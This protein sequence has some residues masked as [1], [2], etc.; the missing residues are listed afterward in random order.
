MAF[1]LLLGVAY[2]ETEPMS[3]VAGATGIAQ[4]P[5]GLELT[6]YGAG[7]IIGMMLWQIGSVPWRQL[8]RRFNRFLASKFEFYKFIIMATGCLVVLF[9]I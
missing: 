9:Y 1:G 7:M 4:I 8:P 6:S 5:I 3:D 2:N